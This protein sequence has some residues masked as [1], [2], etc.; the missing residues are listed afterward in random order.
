MKI[1]ELADLAGVTTDTVRFYERRGVL[2]PPARQPSGYR[3]YTAATAERIRLAKALQAH[4]FTLDEIIDA[5]HS[6]DAGT[7]CADERWRL[8]HVL[9]RIDRQ[10]DELGSLRSTVVDTM[11]AC[12]AD[13]C[14]FANPSATERSRW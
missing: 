12:D 3:V 8:E 1:G 2:P 13:M 4:G 5:I 11:A 14:R 10:L 6:L 9:D 7:T